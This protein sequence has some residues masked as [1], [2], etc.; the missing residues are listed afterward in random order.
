LAPSYSFHAR[1]VPLFPAPCEFEEFEFECGVEEF[2]A[3][4]FF[5]AH[6]SAPTFRKVNDLYLKIATIQHTKRTLEISWFRLC[7]ANYDWPPSKKNRWEDQK[8]KAAVYL[9]TAKAKD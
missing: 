5:L 2:I 9:A 3:S 1:D 8:T 4:A 7:L 6:P